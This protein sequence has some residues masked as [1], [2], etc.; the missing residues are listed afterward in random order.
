MMGQRPPEA[1][2]RPSSQAASAM[3]GQAALAQVTRQ[4]DAVVQPVLDQ[5]T[6][7][8]GI[9]LQNAGQVDEAAALFRA[10]LQAYPYDGV[11]TY[12][13]AVILMQRGE[14]AAVT[15]M[16]A[17]AVAKTPGFAPLW[18]AYGTV[19]QG[20]ARSADALT[21]YG[22]ALM[23][24]PQYPEALINSGVLLR[25][26]HRHIEALDRFQRVLAFKPDNETALGNCGI[27]LTEFKR[28]EEAVAMFQRL[29]KVNPRY[30]WGLGL[31]AYERLHACDWTDFEANASQ[32]VEGIKARQRTCKSL[33]LMAFSDDVAAH[34]ISAQLFATRFPASKTPLW[35]GQR[36]RH[37][38]IR[39][40]YVSPDLREHPVGHLM[41][42]IFEHH[43]KSRFETI[44]ISLGIDDGS[45]LRGRMLVSFDKFIDARM[46]SSREI[47]TLMREM[48]IDIAVDLA[49]YTAD[50]RTDVFAH[51]PVPVQ[52]NFLGYP[53]TLGTSFM[54][55]I[56]ADRYVIPAEHQQYYNEK[57]VYLPDAYLPT[58]AGLQI[59][60]HT[61]SRQECGLPDEGVVFC[62]FSHDYKISPPLF[63]IW[64]RLLAQVPGSVLWLMSRSEGSQRNLRAEAAKR[65]VDASRL[66]F[67]G[68]V[69]RVEDHLARYRQAD[70][71]LDTHPYNAH[72]TSADALMAGLPV[73]TYMGGAFP[74]R[75]AASLLHAIGMPE[76]VADSAAG[77]EALALHLARH[78]E[79]LSAL[80][81]KLASHRHTHALFDTDR[82]C[83]NLES[84]YVSMWRQAE[85][86]DARDALSHA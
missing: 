22:N 2:L 43:D 46:M 5:S 61:P 16:L 67:A 21:A 27:I 34:Q 31:L 10:Y 57:V 4:V 85:L 1:T 19:L 14:G 76:L 6:L 73:V 23:L 81:A 41:A 83:Q 32:M 64:M 78:P 42:G 30:D 51:R 18:M 60:D 62:S 68:R 35:T 72:T 12:S 33:P 71:F 75:V 44:A 69:P 86:G 38:K 82:F 17:E 70:I 3:I 53:G 29:L 47:A 37:K 20:A 50:S 8:R 48:E 28:S 55:Y 74:A 66:I 77:Y 52:V 39:L 63:D 84:V 25:E 9:E 7:I 36:Y 79:E 56:I 80:K 65:G 54:D 11:A 45:R 40:A 15:A 13:L 24:N 49:G 58:D 59:A 26:A